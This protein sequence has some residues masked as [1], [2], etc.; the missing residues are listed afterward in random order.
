[1][2]ICQTTIGT[3]QQQNNRYNQFCIRVEE[4]LSQGRLPDMVNTAF[5]TCGY[6]G[7][8]R[9]QEDRRVGHRGNI[10]ILQKSNCCSSCFGYL[11][12][13]ALLTKNYRS[14]NQ[15]FI[16]NSINEALQLRNNIINMLSTNNFDNVQYSN[17][18]LN[19]TYNESSNT[20]SD[21]NVSN[22]IEEESIEEYQDV[23]EDFPNEYLCPINLTPMKDPVICMDGHSYERKAIERW[24]RNHNN[25]PKT[26]LRLDS[27][28]LIPNHTLKTVIQE[29]LNKYKNNSTSNVNI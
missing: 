22:T 13:A 27:K 1:M 5:T 3:H 17:V 18:N 11:K 12:K 23:G 29:Y 7:Y 16:N 20:N 26:G 19:T 8:W 2:S 10:Q 24:F 21:S 9:V 25:S 6:N 4:V 14:R 28:T 15:R